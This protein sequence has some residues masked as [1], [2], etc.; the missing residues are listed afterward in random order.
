MKWNMMTMNDDNNGHEGKMRNDGN[1]EEIQWRNGG[2][3]VWYVGNMK[4]NNEESENDKYEIMKNE[5][6]KWWI[7]KKRNIKPIIW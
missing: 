7:M 1:E 2:D 4:R 6:M 3:I 5:L